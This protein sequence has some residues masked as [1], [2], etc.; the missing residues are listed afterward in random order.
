MPSVTIARR[1]IEARLGLL[2]RVLVGNALELE[3][4]CGTQT[5]QCTRV[6]KFGIHESTFRHPSM[7]G[8]ITTRSVPGGW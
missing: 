1:G 3:R 2:A 4:T 7:P 8:P 5:V 6:S